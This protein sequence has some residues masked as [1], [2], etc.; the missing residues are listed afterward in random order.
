M[1]STEATLQPSSPFA[2]PPAV[3]ASTQHSLFLDPNQQPQA[4]QPDDAAQ[5]Q[6]LDEDEPDDTVKS[7]N[8]ALRGLFR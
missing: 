6:D 2:Q 7:I 4:A 1:G 3:D 5:V 8:D